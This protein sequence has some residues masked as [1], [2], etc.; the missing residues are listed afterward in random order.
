MTIS[1]AVLVRISGG[2]NPK[3]KRSMPFEDTIRRCPILKELQ[4]K[5]YLFPDSDLSGMLDDLLEKRVI[6]LSES[7]RPKDIRRT[8][9]PKYCRYHRMVSHPLKKCVTLKEHIMRL[10]KDRTII[11]DLDD[12]VEANHIL[13]QT[14]GLSIIQFGGLEPFVLH[15][16]RLPNPATQERSL[17]VNVFD[18]LAVNMT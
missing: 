12:V 7:K 15:E 13:C 3:E 9:D 11:L 17:T 6:Q 2:R 4:E 8:T 10:I 1:K 5:R 18:K 14:R 16:H